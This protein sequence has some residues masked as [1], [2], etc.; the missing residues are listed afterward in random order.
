MGKSLISD[1]STPRLKLALS[2]THT[3]THHPHHPSPTCINRPSLKAEGSQI[4]K[5]YMRRVKELC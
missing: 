1:K 3:N 2:P 5:P 4:E